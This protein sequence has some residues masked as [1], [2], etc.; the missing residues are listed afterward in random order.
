MRKLE[1]ER[2][3]PSE[4]S[5]EDRS[6]DDDTLPSGRVDRTVS[7]GQAHSEDTHFRPKSL[8][9][10]NNRSSLLNKLSHQLCSRKKNRRWTIL[11]LLHTTNPRRSPCLSRNPAHI[12]N[13]FGLLPFMIPEHSF[14]AIGPL[15]V[16]LGITM[17]LTFKLN[18]AAMDSVQQQMFSIMPWIMMFVMA[19]FA[20]G[21]LLYWVTS[22]ILTL[23]QQS[24]LY[25]KHPQL[26][27]AAA[28]EKAK[29]AKG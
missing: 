19:P 25:S 2:S 5:K 27:A 1:W 24:Y 9:G 20:A 23:A 22:N 3:K 26:K 10:I 4:R 28:A 11:P 18:P 7:S 6:G 15:A 21:L 16:L 13:L 17:W 12:L 8:R 14:L 29:A